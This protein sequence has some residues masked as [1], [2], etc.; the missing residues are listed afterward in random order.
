VKRTTI[1]HRVLAL[2]LTV[3]AAY[4]GYTLFEPLVADLFAQRQRIDAARTRVQKY[5]KLAA[6]QEAWER[7]RAAMQADSSAQAIWLPG[8]TPA[9]AAAVLQNHLRDQVEAAGATIHSIR[10]LPEQSAGELN[11]VTLSARLSTSQDSFRALLYGL[12]NELPLTLV[13]R[14]SVRARYTPGRRTAEAA[15]V[16]NVDLQL[17]GFMQHRATPQ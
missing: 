12:E 15:D 14:V 9:L 3:T 4:S 7:T 17:S 8:T 10:T 6:S 1:R 13:E 5:R 11:R 2:L 16:M